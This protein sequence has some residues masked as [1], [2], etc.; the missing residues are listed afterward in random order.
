MYIY[1]IWEDVDDWAEDGGGT[2]LED[3]FANKKDADRECEKLNQNRPSK[4]VSY[5]VTKGAVR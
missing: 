3:I 4:K 5:F 1:L 2:Y